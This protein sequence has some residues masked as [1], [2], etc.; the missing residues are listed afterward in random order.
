[1][2]GIASDHEANQAFLAPAQ[3]PVVPQQGYAMDMAEPAFI[4]VAVAPE[5]GSSSSTLLGAGL[6]GAAVAGAA[7]S[8]LA[9][10]FSLISTELEWILL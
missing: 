3:L 7:V 10:V 9:Y 6:L 5:T 8:M 1:M 4:P 2:I